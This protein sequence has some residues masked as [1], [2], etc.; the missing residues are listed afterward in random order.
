MSLK[1][2][3]DKVEMV[4]VKAHNGNEFN[5]E[6]DQLANNAAKQYANI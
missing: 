6:V 1:K 4:C 2:D 5:E 3:F